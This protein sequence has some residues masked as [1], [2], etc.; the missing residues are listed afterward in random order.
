MTKKE[1]V[2]AFSSKV[3]HS[4]MKAQLLGNNMPVMTQSLKGVNDPTCLMA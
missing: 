3:I 4:Q 1:G 2:D